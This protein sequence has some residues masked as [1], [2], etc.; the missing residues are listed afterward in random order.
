VSKNCQ[1]MAATRLAV[2]GRH[3]VVERTGRQ[4]TMTVV[5]SGNVT[6]N[7]TQTCWNLHFTNTLTRWQHMY[8]PVA[9]HSVCKHL[10]WQLR[11]HVVPA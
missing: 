11:Q 9:K 6:Y 3:V 4:R 7:D 10:L 2:I 5:T 1:Q 8:R